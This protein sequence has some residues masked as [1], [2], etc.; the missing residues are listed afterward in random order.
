MTDAKG[1]GPGVVFPP[2][3]LFVAGFL[4][5]WVIDRYLYHLWLPATLTAESITERVGAFS[6]VGGLAIAFSGIV[7]FH[8]ADTAIF[9]NRDASRLVTS[10]PYKFTRNPMYS[11]MAIAYLGISLMYSVGWAVLLLPLVLLALYRMVIA[12]EERYLADAFGDQYREYQ[13]NVGR[14]W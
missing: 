4:V 12:R 5:G 7:T 6:L 3:I 1:R 9:P 14:W 8:T 10:G 11:G 13:R 2:P